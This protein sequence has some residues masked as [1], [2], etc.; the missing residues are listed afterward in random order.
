MHIVANPASSSTDTPAPVEEPPV[1]KRRSDKMGLAVS[2][3]SDPDRLSKAVDALR[4]D[5]FAGSG[6]SARETWLTTWI[7]FH[8]TVF[9]DGSDPFPLTVDKIEHVVALFKA[10]GY[11]SVKNY[12]HRAKSEHIA[13]FC[14]HKTSWTP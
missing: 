2:I 5:K 7:L 14:R 12:T 1:T 3:G 11:R 9:G 13:T 10:A 6:V 8:T 4:R